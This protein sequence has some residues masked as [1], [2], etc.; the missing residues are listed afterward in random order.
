MQPSNSSVYRSTESEI[1]QA[2]E[3]VTYAKSVFLNVDLLRSA[4]EMARDS[5]VTDIAFFYEDGLTK[6]QAEGW[7]KSFNQGRFM[8]M[9]RLNPQ[10][11][12]DILE[13][14]L[15]RTVRELS[16]DEAHFQ[17]PSLLN[18]LAETF[19]CEG[20]DGSIRVRTRLLEPWQALILV[21]P[22]LLVTSAWIANQLKWSG[23]SPIDYQDRECA[24]FRFQRW[25]SDST[26]PV[27]DDPF[28]DH[29]CRTQGL[30]E[31]HMHLNGTT[32]AEKV[33]S[34]ALISPQKVVGALT[35]KTLKREFGLH[36]AVGNGVDRLL[37]QEDSQLQPTK[38]MLRVEN[39]AV[40]KA[41]LLRCAVEGAATLG[42]KEIVISAQGPLSKARQMC[43]PHS[44]LR[45]GIVVTE[46]WQLVTLLTSFNNRILSE[47]HGYAFW[48]YALIR[49]QFCRLLVQQ[50]QHKGFDQF[51]Y[52]T[53]NELREATEQDYAE[54]FRQIERGHQQVVDFLEGRF[55]PKN[56]PDKTAA[57]I[58]KILRGYLK[59]LS[60]DES[61]Q[62]SSEQCSSKYS[63]L[64]EL[65]ERVREL[66]RGRSDSP[67]SIR[68][69]R[70]GLVPHFIK[71]TTYSERASFFTNSRV[72]PFCR[73]VRLRRE[74]DHSAR[75]L[76]T[77]LQR[78]RG[79]ERL[80]RGVDAASNERHAGPEV[81]APVFRRMRTAGVRRFTYH[82]GEDFSH[83]ASGLRAI[84]EA[85]MYLGLDAGCRIGHG[86]AAG[87]SPK[88]WWDSVQGY[89]VLPLE[90]RLDD[91]VF[92]WDT[93]VNAGIPIGS[94]TKIEAEIRS[95]TM[96]IWQNPTL[97][98]DVLATAWKLRALDP[99]VRDTGSSDVDPN[100]RAEAMR[101]AEA[102]D[103]H[104]EAHAQFLLRH[105]VGAT[106]KQLQRCQE[107]IVVFRKDDVLSPKVL[108]GLQQAVLKRLADC[109][110]A[111]ETL[112][113]SNVRISIHE[114]YNEHHVVNW[115][116]LGKHSTESSVAI[117][118]GSDD[119]G[120]FA[121]GLRQ[122]Y[123]HLLR[124]LRGRAKNLG[125]PLH[126]EALVQ[127]VCTNAKRF[128]F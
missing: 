6:V 23:H 75:A 35:Y 79:L 42:K 22:P 81:F 32:E 13:K 44:S 15:L 45:L 113:T 120:I 65:L 5:R 36:V 61:G 4:E 18:R 39:A 118:M 115:L 59:F 40:L 109:T 111:I 87:I 69:L 57:L 112:P 1:F 122:E 34:D 104:P 52:I 10:M 46:A 100:R 84:S 125:N 26:L 14:R 110:I 92:A 119:P 48:H 80:I 107:E 20:S 62:V 19:L 89:V 121:T 123:A 105:G 43:L 126:A 49:S 8:Q 41:M 51:Q 128:R 91:L 3:M 47:R 64:S 74:T 21:V 117:V 86:T 76:I 96:R 106:M 11:T 103:R 29:L 16:L 24:I 58:G 73:D 85:V 108:R 54:R 95:L 78:T 63:S 88:K 67:K 94:I 102:R 56:H 72:R 55:A 101:Y 12:D 116:G 27:D 33:W 97:T 93:L 25:L 68:R 124:V 38:L 66:E 9:S 53:L 60:E 70:L 83:L 82:V 114:G 127:R 99:L 98:P 17:L 77:L 90:E 2:L 30:D 7:L 50:A 28:L 31:V 37:R 71:Q